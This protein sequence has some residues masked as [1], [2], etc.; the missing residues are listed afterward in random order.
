MALGDEI[1]QLEPV[2]L[3]QGVVHDHQLDL[4]FFRQ[5][6]LD[7]DAHRLPGHKVGAALGKAREVGRDLDKGAVFLHAAHDAHHGLTHGEPGRIFLPCAQQFPDGQHKAALYIPVLD[8][9]QDLLAHAHPV[10][11][12]GDAAHRH[13]VDGQQGT[14][15]AAHI[16]ERAKRL[17]MGHGAGQD[18]AGL[19]SVQ[20]VGLAHLLRQRAGEPVEG[21]TVLVGVQRLDHKAGG[22]A[23]PRQHRNVPHGAV[24]GTIGALGKG[25]WINI[26]R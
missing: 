4:H 7:V 22:A 25:F 24:C 16:T 18:I 23:H 8:G 13:A 3:A 21:L 9:A 26:L 2:A 20:I 11:G 14:D 15:A 19:Q 6:V 17:D 1:L 5:D 12:G 10:G